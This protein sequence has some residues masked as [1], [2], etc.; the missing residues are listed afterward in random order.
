M[1][2]PISGQISWR[3][4]RSSLFSHG[5]LFWGLKKLPLESGVSSCSHEPIPVQT[6]FQFVARNQLRLW[7]AACFCW[8]PILRKPR[9]PN[10]R[11]CCPWG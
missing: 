4:K 3:E 8:S 10:T 2:L 6:P 11:S 9:T 7:R 1:G 5:Y